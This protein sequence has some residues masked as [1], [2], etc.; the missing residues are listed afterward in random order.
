MT[1]S[2]DELVLPVWNDDAEEVRRLLNNDDVNITRIDSG[3]TETWR[4]VNGVHGE[5]DVVRSEPSYA[6]LLLIFGLFF[7][8][9]SLKA[10]NSKVS[11][12]S[13][14]IGC[15]LFYGIIYIYPNS[16]NALIDNDKIGKEKV[17]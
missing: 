5:K 6:Y 3:E 7:I 16:M 9:Y 15:S 11:I 13:G 2:T 17:L 8:I 1:I 4:D 14:I 10:V 12:V